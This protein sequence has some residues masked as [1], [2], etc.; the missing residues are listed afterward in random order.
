ML[1][2]LWLSCSL[3]LAASCGPVSAPGGSS[4]RLVSVD[5]D[6]VALGGFD[7]VGYFEAGA[8]EAGDDGLAVAFG[9]ATYLFAS[10]SRRA[11]FDGARHAPRYGGF[12]AAAVA[13]GNLSLAD[14]E[15]FAVVEGALLL[16][17]SDDL[18]AQFLAEPAASLA[19]ADRN[20]P[21]LVAEHGR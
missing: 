10:D 11:A 8:A 7:P 13:L 9:G 14:P 19:A 21:G 18:R 12:C 6:G 1:R 3:L 2:A 5:E 17:A 4:A 20:W 16:F 15:V